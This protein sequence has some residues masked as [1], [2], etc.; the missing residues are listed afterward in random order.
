MRKL[1]F[2]SI[3]LLSAFLLFSCEL[4]YPKQEEE[5]TIHIITMGFSYVNLD[6]NILEN[7]LRDQHGMTEQLIALAESSCCNW[8]V[9]EFN[10]G[11][12]EKGWTY[13]QYDGGNNPIWRGL[14]YRCYSNTE[15]G[16]A[17]TYT[18]I[19]ENDEEGVKNAIADVL[20]EN[21]DVKENDL[22]FFYYSGHGDADGL[23]IPY[24][25][26]AG[27]TYLSPETLFGIMDDFDCFQ[28]LLIDCC[29]SG[30]FIQDGD[31]EGTI[32]YDRSEELDK[33]TVLN[34]FDI[35]ANAFIKGFE[36]GKDGYPKRFTISAASKNQKSLDSDQHAN[37][38]YARYY[39]A[40]TIWALDYLGYDFEHFSGAYRVHGKDLTAAGLYEHAYE[41]LTKYTRMTATPNV[42]ASRYNLVLF[43]Y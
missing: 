24:Y 30:V 29:Y 39:G 13:P 31:L 26:M 32:G 25:G 38:D 40:F 41:N 35:I 4:F 6:G 7:T 43:D 17:K 33:Q 27:Y 18:A 3:V 16:Q 23:V 28:M 2:I 9:I 42:T 14:G 15:Y 36:K 12:Y 22:L 37:H 11:K 1:Y 34:P 20:R 8:N 21:L 19:K 10:D 5:R